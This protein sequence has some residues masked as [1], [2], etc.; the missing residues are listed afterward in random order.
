M[1]PVALTLDPAGD[2]GAMLKSVK[3]QLRAVPHRGLELRRAAL[4]EPGDPRPRGRVRSRG[5]ASTTTASGTG[6]RRPR[7]C[8]P[9]PASGLG[10]TPRRAPRTL[11]ARR[12]RRGR[13]T[14]S[15][16][17]A[18][19]YSAEVHDGATV[20]RLAE[21]DAR[22]PCG[23]SSATAHDPD[24]G[25]R[26]PSDFPLARLDQA[27]VDRLAGDGRGGGGHLSADAA[28][29]RACSSTAWWTRRAA[30]TSTRCRCGCPGCRPARPGARRGSAWSTAPRCCAAP[31]SG[32]GVDRSRCRSCTARPT[33]R[34]THHDWRRAPSGPARGRAGPA[35]RRRPRRAA[36]T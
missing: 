11:P 13:A 24:A 21:R 28:A 15:S 3:E 14:G 4:P 5:S 32:T 20:R 25:G 1:F 8:S 9:A 2:W 19:T 17:S 12:G 18:W 7:R 29:G 23:R 27:A 6:G 10:A 35:A 36:S 26:T 33:C 30:P 34:S 16:S 31:W 22:A